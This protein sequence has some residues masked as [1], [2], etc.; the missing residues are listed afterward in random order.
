MLLGPAQYVREILAAADRSSADELLKWLDEALRRVAANRM[1][2][3]D[4]IDAA[5]DEA[6]AARLRELAVRSGFR[7]INLV[8]FHEADGTMLGWRL[9]A[10]TA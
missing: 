1:R 2:L 7:D 8:P 6:H 3:E 9:E 5:M 10:W 4:M